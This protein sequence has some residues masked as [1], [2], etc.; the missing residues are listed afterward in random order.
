[1]SMLGDRRYEGEKVP[2]S[3]DSSGGKEV[4]RRGCAEPVDATDMVDALRR[5]REG[6]CAGRSAAMEPRFLDG[7]C[8]LEGYGGEPAGEKAC[9]GDA[10]LTSGR[11]ETKV[12]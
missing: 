2:C 1:M 7:S 6:G 10:I 12:W 8:A 9:G 3:W 11:G 5:L 4:C